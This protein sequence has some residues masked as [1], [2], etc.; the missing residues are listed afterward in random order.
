LAAGPQYGVH[1]QFPEFDENTVF[2][3]IRVRQI[4]CR[5]VEFVLSGPI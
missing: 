3:T 2:K 5:L 1:P 4:R